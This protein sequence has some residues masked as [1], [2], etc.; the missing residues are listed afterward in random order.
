MTKGISIA[1]PGSGN[2]LATGEGQPRPKVVL[3]WTVPAPPPPPTHE[4]GDMLYYD[5]KTESWIPLR[6][7][8]PAGFY[9]LTH[10]G[11]VPAWSET[12]ECS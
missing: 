2:V 1:F 10:N 9:V 5:K 6:A 12:A 11:T 8:S 7:P 3:S 4:Q